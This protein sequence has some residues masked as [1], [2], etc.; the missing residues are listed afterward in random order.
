MHATVTGVCKGSTRKRARV[1]GHVLATETTLEVDVMTVGW[2]K[3]IRGGDACWERA[4][5]RRSASTSGLSLLSLLRWSTTSASASACTTSPN[6]TTPT[7]SQGTELLTPKVRVPLVHVRVPVS[8]LTVFSRVSSLQVRG[9]PPVPRRDPGRKDQ[10]LQPGRSSRYRP[11]LGACL[12]EPN[13]AESRGT[14]TWRLCFSDH[15][16][17]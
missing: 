1:T 9:F 7:F 5:R 3:G 16:L 11:P 15:G 17:L 8:T 12:T 13:R 10:V 14:D 4:Q 2:R 6:W